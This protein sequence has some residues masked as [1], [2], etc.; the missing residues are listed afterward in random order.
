[1]EV[2]PCDRK[3]SAPFFL[4][5]IHIDVGLLC[6]ERGTQR[7]E[8][9]VEKI[10]LPAEVTIDKSGWFLVRAITDVEE[11][12]RFASTAPWYVEIDGHSMKPD[13]EA[14]AFFTS[15]GNFERAVLICDNFAIGADDIVGI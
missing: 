11:T 2:G 3:E 10:G 12:F 13:R 4:E 14:A 5:R 6:C 15:E 9:V 7:R 1:M 8:V